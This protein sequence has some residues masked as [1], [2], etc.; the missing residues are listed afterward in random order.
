MNAMPPNAAIA[1]TDS[2]TVAALVAVSPFIASYQ[3]AY[4]MPDVMPP[5]TAAKA[6]PTV[7]A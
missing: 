2:C 6:S 1:G 7:V 5:E 3:I 4:P